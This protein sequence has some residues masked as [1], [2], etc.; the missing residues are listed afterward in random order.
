MDD[1]SFSGHPV[2]PNCGEGE[3]ADTIEKILLLLGRDPIGKV[4]K[5]LNV[6]RFRRGEKHCIL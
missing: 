5:P 2:H 6:D 4:L 3:S 1:L